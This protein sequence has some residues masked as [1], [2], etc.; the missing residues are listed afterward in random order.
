MTSE[1]ELRR[2]E[3]QLAEANRRAAERAEQIKAERKAAADKKKNATRG[4]RW[5]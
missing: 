2:I 3:R 1:K 5:K 4:D